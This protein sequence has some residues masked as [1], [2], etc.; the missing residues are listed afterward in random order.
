[1]KFKGRI[2]R[3][4]AERLRQH[5][6]HLMRERFNEVAPSISEKVFDIVNEWAAAQF[7]AA[8]LEVL[9]RYKL[10]D[11]VVVVNVTAFN[12]TTKLWDRRY[13]FKFPEGK[14]VAMPGNDGFRGTYKSLYSSEIPALIPFCDDIEAQRVRYNAEERALR[15]FVDGLPLRRDVAERYPDLAAMIAPLWTMQGLAA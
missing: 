8:D 13:G 11:D 2:R 5:Y 9:R 1:M 6:S 4:D 15:D 3:S 7:P 10:V 12:E 14:I